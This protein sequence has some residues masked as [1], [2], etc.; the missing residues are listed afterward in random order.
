MMVLEKAKEN[1]VVM[2]V[3]EVPTDD[4]KF[5]TVAICFT[6]TDEEEM[7]TFGPVAFVRHYLMVNETY[8]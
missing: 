2:A 1:R 4:F 6:E 3:K 7:I 5:P 8:G